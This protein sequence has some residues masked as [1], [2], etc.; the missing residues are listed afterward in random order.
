MIKSTY[1]KTTHMMR[2]FIT[3]LGIAFSSLLIIKTEFFYGLTGP[4]DFAETQIGPG[5]TRTFIKI[6][7]IILIFVSLYYLTGGLGDVGHAVLT[8]T[9]PTGQ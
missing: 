4:M 3:L 8:P 7:G 9:V 2:F 5:G 1:L 6:V